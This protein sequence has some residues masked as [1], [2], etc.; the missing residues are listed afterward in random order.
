MRGAPRD[1]LPKA[2]GGVPRRGKRG[3]QRHR[4]ARERA[5]TLARPPPPPPPPPERVNNLPFTRPTAPGAGLPPWAPPAAPPGAPPKLLASLLPSDAAVPGRLTGA[6]AAAALEAVRRYADA[7]FTPRWRPDGRVA[8]E[9]LAERR[10]APAQRL[11]AACVAQ[12]RALLV[13]PHDVA[14]EQAHVAA[15][16]RA[17]ARCATL[18]PPPANLSMGAAALLA[19]L[20]GA[21]KPAPRAGATPELYDP[22]EAEAEAAYDPC[23]TPWEPGA[24]D[25]Y[26][27]LEG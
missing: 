27:P 21:V 15:A 24:G 3:G 1:M 16:A 20:R 18:P 22:C 11:A 17:L 10:A 2:K 9:T 5:R 7:R 26:D 6:A 23:G 14:A 13:R 12:A 19:A 8:A 4:A 25:T